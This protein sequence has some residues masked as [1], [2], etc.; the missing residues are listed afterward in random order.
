PAKTYAAQRHAI[1]D[2]LELAAPLNAG[3]LAPGISGSWAALEA[4][5]TDAQ[6]SDEEEGK[7]AAAVRAARLTAC[8][9]PRA[10][11]TALSYQV[12]ERKAAGQKLASRLQE[13]GTNRDRSEIVAAQLRQDNGLPLRRSWRFGSDVAAV[14]RMN[15]LLADPAKALKQVSGYVES[16]FRRMY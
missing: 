4:L 5:L 6:D 3:A 13:V 15:G 2:A 9:W 11:L 16:S 14:A 8:S 7:V 10:E 12:N 1:D